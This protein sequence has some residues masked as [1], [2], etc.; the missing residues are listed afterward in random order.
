MTAMS[1]HLDIEEFDR[2]YDLADLLPVSLARD[3]LADIDGHC[4]AVVLT[5]DGRI[6]YSGSGRTQDDSVGTWQQVDH[7]SP[8]PSVYSAN[9]RRG[10]RIE[11][12]HE[13]ETIGYLVLEIGNDHTLDDDRLLS[14]GRFVARC[15]NRVINLNY[16]YR[17]TAGLHGQ[18]VADS[19]DRLKKKADQLACSE[20]K[21]RLLAENLE[22]EV[23]KKTREVRET[24]LRL[25][26]QEKMASIGQLAAGVAHEINNPVGFVISNLN[27]L[28]ASSEDL[29]DLIGSYRRLTALLSAKTKDSGTVR[30]IREQMAVIDRRIEDIDLDFIIEDTASLIDESLDGAKRVKIIVQNLRDFTHPSI[31]TA[32]SVDLNNCLE[33]TLAMLS[34]HTMPEVKI[35]RKYGAIPQVTCHLREINHAL[36][37]ILKNAFQSVGEQGEITI[38]TTAEEE[39]VTVRIADTGTGIDPEH[40]SSIFDPFFTTREVGSGTG[41]GLF[42][43]YSTVKSH[44][45]TIA[46]DSEI[47]SGSTFTVT[48]PM[49]GIEKD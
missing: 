34:S 26:Q 13:L 17:M 24:Q 43:A 39:A 45:G 2:E 30:Q 23:E 7:T 44:G 15:I 47:G 14:T 9:G 10:V 27:T 16:R 3:L 35:S 48:I 8:A 11:L 36:F 5:I 4:T 46:V 33:T 38:S 6:H 20:E 32:E 21:Y 19:Y 18:V 29:A 1:D 12:T 49:E 37:N 25:L 42:Q 40:L 31:E 22:I 28:K 41:L